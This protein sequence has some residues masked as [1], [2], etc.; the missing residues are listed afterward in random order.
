MKL[1][2]LPFADYE[3]TI[4]KSD[5]NNKDKLYASHQRIQ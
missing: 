2:A 3:V 4:S 1:N 5:K